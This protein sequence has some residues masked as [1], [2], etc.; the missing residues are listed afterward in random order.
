M[1]EKTSARF[2]MAGVRKLAHFLN[3][4]V[5]RRG[6]GKDGGINRVGEGESKIDF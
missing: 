4:E 3:G 5:Y 2:L 1:H 6:I